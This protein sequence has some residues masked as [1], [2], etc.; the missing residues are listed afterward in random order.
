MQTP[1][2]SSAQQQ[3]QQQQPEGGGVL[4]AESISGSRGKLLSE[5]PYTNF[6]VNKEDVRVGWMRAASAA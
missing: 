1:S 3:Q 2:S 5:V 6:S 4:R